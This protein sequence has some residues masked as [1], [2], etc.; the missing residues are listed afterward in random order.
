MSVLDFLFEGQPPASVTT[1]GKT[2]ENLPAWYSDYTQGLIA[3]ANAIAAEPFQAYGYQR[4]APLNPMQT[5]AYQGTA[6]LEGQIA[7]AYEQARTTI[8]GAGYPGALEAAQPFINQ[9]AQGVTSAGAADTSALAMPFL[10]QA[11][12]YTQTGAQ[13]TS[14]AAIPF[15]QNAANLSAAGSQTVPSTISSYMDPYQQQVVDRIGEL[16]QR[17]LT[18][19]LLPT[20]Q[21]QG[22]S[23]GQFGGTRGAEAMGRAL[24][25]V[26]ESTL[27]A[28]TQALSQGYGQA[29]QL[30][31]AD[32]ARQLQAAQQQAGFGTTLAGLQSADLQRQLAAGQQIGALGTTT[33]GLESADLQRQLAAAQQLG[34]LGTTAGT[35][36]QQDLNRLL[37]SGVAQGQLA[38]EQQASS[39][40]RLGALEAAG[41]AQQADAQRNLDLAYQD[42]LEERDYDRSNIAF[43][44]AALRGLEVPTSTAVSSTGPASV[45]QPSPLSQLASAATGAAGLTKVLSSLG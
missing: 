5:A 44:N 35:L 15:L 39:L 11:Q 36:T 21:A 30:S 38:G 1:Y 33:A 22:I 13:G 6:A 45:Y 23:S 16:G 26:Q 14:G 2:V 12:Q 40:Q 34:Q 32:M 27:A 41:A 20:L 10:Q 9:A 8:Q 29:A 31:Q 28:Q 18:E 25:D 42:F 24:R 43:L 17:Q 37:Q 19:N 7:P 3:R 4:L